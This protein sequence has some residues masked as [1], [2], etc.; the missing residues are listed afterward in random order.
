MKGRQLAPHP[1]VAAYP[2]KL[3]HGLAAVRRRLGVPLYVTGGTVRDW[4]IGRVSHDIDIT[5]DADPGQCARIYAAAAGGTVVP[6]DEEHGIVRVAGDP[7]VDFCRFRA[8]SLAADLHS[9]DFTVNALALPVGSDG[10]FAVEGGVIDPTGGVADLKAGRIRMTSVQALEEDPLRLLR[11]FRFLAVLAMEIEAGTERAIRERA[12]LLARPAGERIAAELDALLCGQSSG[13]A[14]R[15]MQACGVL[16]VVLPEVAAGGGCRQPASHHLDVLGH[17]I[18]AVEQMT[19]LC[20]EPTGA[21]APSAFTGHLASYVTVAANRVALLWAALLHDIGKPL[22]CGQK[23]GGRITFYNHDNAALPAIAAIAHRL[24]WGRRQKE[25]ISRLVQ[26][27]MWPFHLCNVI[28]RQPVSGRAVL[29]LAR[30]MEDD[31]AGLFLL[32]MADS[33]AGQGPGKPADCEERLVA[34]YDEVMRQYEQRIRSVLKGPRLVTGHD[35]IARF[36]L[37]PGPRFKEIL[38]GVASAQAAGE[39]SD[40]REALAWVARFLAEERRKG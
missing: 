15:A 7:D 30:K 26:R 36:G 9:R 14:L 12:H 32:A 29:R 22:T 4:L 17:S 25:R 21:F 40:R 20:R 13:A 23:A 28:R 33:L 1:V 39:V 37:T 19:R 8:A 3:Y 16:A 31:L 18:E 11:A 10:R 2:P 38:N 34:L 24:R 27:H 6:L 5:A 35:L